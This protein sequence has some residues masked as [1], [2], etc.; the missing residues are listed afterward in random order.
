MHLL[1]YNNFICYNLLHKK[2]LHNI[3]RCLYLE[4]NFLS[5]KYNL[6]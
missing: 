6:Y 1:I 3:C 5:I 2:L 4:L